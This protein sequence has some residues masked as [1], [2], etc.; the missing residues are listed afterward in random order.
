MGE[1]ASDGRCSHGIL[2]CDLI[3]GGLAPGLSIGLENID[4]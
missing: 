4:L 3:K 1:P 2:R